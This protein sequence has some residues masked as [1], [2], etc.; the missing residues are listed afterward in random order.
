MNSKRLFTLLVTL[1][2]APITVS[3]TPDAFYEQGKQ[4]YQ[5]PVRGGCMQCHGQSGNEPVMPLYPKIGGQ[6]ELY[7]YNQ[8]MDYKNKKRQNGLYIPMEV[9]MQPFSADEIK[10][11]SYFL[12]KQTVF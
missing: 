4:L 12:A 2:L 7:L 5:N 6:S 11:M 3:A 10:A 1:S 9:A 8:L